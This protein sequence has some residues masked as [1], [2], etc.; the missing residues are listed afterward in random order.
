MMVPRLCALFA[1]ADC[2]CK[3]KMFADVAICARRGHDTLPLNDKISARPADISRINL[4]RFPMRPEGGFRYH[5]LQR[6]RQVMTQAA[7]DGPN[8]L[9]YELSPATTFSPVPSPSI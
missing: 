4:Q 7:V 5:V 2:A 9:R 8:F 1:G 3:K 6:G